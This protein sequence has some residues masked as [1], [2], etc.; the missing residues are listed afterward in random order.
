MIVEAES[1]DPTPQS[2]WAAALVELALQM[3][4]ATYDTWL[5]DTKAVS[6]VNDSML[7][8][9]QSSYAADWLSE[10][11]APIISKTVENIAGRSITLRYRVC[12]DT[13]IPADL[14]AEHR[15]IPVELVEFDPTKRLGFVMVPNYGLQF[16]KPLVGAQ[17]FGLWTTIRSYAQDGGTTGRLTW[18]T[19]QTLA[20]IDANGNRQLI[21]GRKRVRAGVEYWKTGWLEILEYHRILWYRRR[22]NIYTFQCLA[23]LPLLTPAQVTKLSLGRQAAH[24]RLLYRCDLDFQQWKQLTLPTLLPDGVMGVAPD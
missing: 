13:I 20:D 11:L 16:W 1:P 17:P 5:A 21:T 15:S 8:A 22:E 3:T 24:R 7:I 4:H 23:S 9:V 6:L 14:A 12:N 10:R 2:I 19:L 18:P